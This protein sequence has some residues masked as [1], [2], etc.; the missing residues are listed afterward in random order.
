M[1]PLQGMRIIE[2]VGIGPGPFAGMMLADMGAEVIAVD[3]MQAGNAPSLKVD[4]C[5]RGKQSIKLDLKSERGRELFLS[6]CESADAVFEGFRPGTV[7][8][9]GIGPDDCLARNPSLVYG[10]MTGWGQTGPLAKTAGHDINY[11]SLSGALHGIGRKD[12][13]PVPPLNLIGDYGGGGMMLAFGLVCALLEVKS[14]GKGQEIDVSMLEGSSALMAM[15]HSMKAVG[16]WSE[17]RNTNLLDGGAHFYDVYETADNKYV[18]FGAI[19]KP[20]MKV[21]V[22]KVGLA[23]CWLE[24]HMNPKYWDALK[25]ELKDL[26]KTRTQAQWC[27]LLEGTDACFSPVLPFWQAHEHPHN[28]ARKSFIE[29]DGLIQP[30]PTPKFSRTIPEVKRGPATEGA[31]TALLLQELGLNDKQIQVLHEQSIVG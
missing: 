31:D 14:S 25:S 23:E 10:R 30:A 3:R 27:K 5:R 2:L 8:K 1:G 21:F 24:R 13:P 6:L 9:L 7:E 22:E 28:Q 29:V 12:E 20:F 17:Q 19:E 18:S 11:I 16:M 15:F 26:F 4:I